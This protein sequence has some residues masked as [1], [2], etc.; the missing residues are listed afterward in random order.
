MLDA[1]FAQGLSGLTSSLITNWIGPAFLLVIAG[2]AIVL[3]IRRQ[4]MA[5]LSFALVGVL[6]AIFIYGGAA[7]FGENGSLTKVGKDV[8]KEV[9]V[10]QPLDITEL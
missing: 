1:I 3:A 6:A 7:L 10:V 5:F 9:N 8:A 2:I 4:L